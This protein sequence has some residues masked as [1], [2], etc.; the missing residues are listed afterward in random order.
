MAFDPIPDPATLLNAVFGIERQLADLDRQLEVARHAASSADGAVSAVANGTPRLV[1]LSITQPALDAANLSG[2]LV[3]LAN[4]IRAVVNQALGRAQDASATATGSLA[5]ILSLQ[6]I[7]APA[8]ALPNIAGFAEA[9]AALTAQVPAIDQRVL[10]RTFTGQVGPATAIVNGHFEVTSLTLAGF[11][12]DADVLADQTLR[13][14]NLGVAQV[15]PLVDTTIDDT[16][17]TIPDNVVAFGNLCLYARGT[18]KIEDRVK[19]LG[20]TGAPAPVGNAGNVTTNIGV[21]A[22]VG[23]IWSMAPVTLRNDA[24]VVG[25]VKTPQTVTSNT[26]PPDVS[27]GVFPAT[28]IQ[29]PNL[30]LQVTFPNPS[31]GDVNLEPADKRSLAP[32]AYRKATIKGVLTLR[33]GTYTFEEFDLESQG[34]LTIDSRAGRVIVHVRGGNLIFRGKETSVSGRANF[35]LGYFGTNMIT[36]TSPFVGTLVAPSALLDLA[37]VAS[38]GYSGAFFAKDI[39]VHPDSTVNFVPYTGAPSLGAF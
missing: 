24:H 5:G 32:G 21:Q 26:T 2:S 31:G 29:L 38:P 25:F 28:F 11:P 16:V 30:A 3:A 4:Q 19:V 37:T 34:T 27:A 36:V 18:L 13:A 9:A 8:G 1:E 17:G 14:I 15:G 20:P 33:A 7:C 12:P 35:F 6:G 23:N 22:R 10:A 39:D